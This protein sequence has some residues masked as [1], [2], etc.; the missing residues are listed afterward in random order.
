MDNFTI[1]QIQVP[2]CMELDLGAVGK[3]YAG[4]IVIGLLKER[5]HCFGASGYRRKYP[6][7][8]QQAGR[9]RLG[10]SESAALLVKELWAS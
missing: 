8:R 6:G 2:E 10:D 7:H 9:Q 5:G 1:A 4:D 3:G